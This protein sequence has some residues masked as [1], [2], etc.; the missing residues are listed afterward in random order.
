[1]SSGQT[2]LNKEKD[3]RKAWN[4]HAKQKQIFD[5]SSPEFAE[6]VGLRDKLEGLCQEPSRTGRESIDDHR[7]R[8]RHLRELRDQIKTTLK[9]VDAKLDGPDE[10]EVDPVVEKARAAAKER[11]KLPRHLRGSAEVNCMLSGGE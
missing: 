10:V 5:E 8:R 6:M 1:M 3:Q 7:A 9:N 2:Q 11:L 4:I